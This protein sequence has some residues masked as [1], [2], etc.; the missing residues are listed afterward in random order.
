[1]N[2]N[3][4]LKRIQPD[5]ERVQACLDGY[6][7]S[8]VGIVDQLGRY[9]ARQSGKK[10][11]P[12]LLILAGRMIGCVAERLYPLGAL[13]ELIHTAS[14]VHDDIID[15]ADTRRGS[16]SVNAAYGNHMSV[17]MG[18]WLYMTAFQVGVAQQNFRILDML[19][20]VSR[21]M[22][23][24]ELIQAEV[25]GRL[26]LTPEASLD[27][28]ARKT[29]YLFSAATALPA[30]S[31]GQ[32]E[33]AIARLTRIGLN[34]GLAFQVVD[35]V[36]DYTADERK[37][38]KPVMGDLREGKLTLPVIYLL[39]SDGAEARRMVEAVV[40]EQG[41]ASV[42]PDA[43]LG[44]LRRAGCLDRAM[45]CA[46]GFAEQARADLLA[47]PSSPHRRTLV[48]ITDFILKRQH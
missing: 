12:A 40:A 2:A 43:L 23:E 41:F 24:G 39:E 22:V 32:S 1:V 19:L 18:D 37:L 45:A 11:R 9:V 48:Q 30:V 6:L 21:K 5:L 15:E 38:G 27:I 17:L 26:D 46:H 10:L 8:P 36:L 42:R 7:G 33:E 3:L 14:L 13:V 28:A 35:D 16:P 44:A 20:D 25:L 31:A 34:L 47:F 4:I 29:A